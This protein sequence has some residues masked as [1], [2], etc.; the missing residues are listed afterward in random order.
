M[1]YNQSKNNI[2]IF[3][4]DKFEGRSVVANP[5][6]KPSFSKAPA[7]G[8]PAR[9]AQPPVDMHPHDKVVA[10]AATPAN[11]EW[12]KMFPNRV[13]GVQV[14]FLLSGVP[15]QLI[16]MHAGGFGSTAA[17]MQERAINIADFCAYG[18][19]ITVNGPAGGAP[20]VHDNLVGGPFGQHPTAA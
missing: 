3:S 5:A 13:L 20:A 14:Q 10:R 16:A 11:A 12:N 6:S 17:E 18:G 1:D 9:A 15:V 2:I 4:L 8:Q 7:T 19:K